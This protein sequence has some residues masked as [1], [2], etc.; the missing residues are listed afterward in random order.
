[1]RNSPQ[2][3]R[4]SLIHEVSRSQTHYGGWDSSGRVISSSQRPLPD[5][6]QHSKDRHAQ[7]PPADKG[8]LIHEVSRSQTHHSGWDSSGRVISSSQR[9]LPD[10]TQHSQDR[11]PCLQWDSNPTISA[12]R[13][14][15]TY[16]LDCA[17]TGT[18]K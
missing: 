7:Q 1:M 4:A 16:A 13:R 2:R 12:G 5:N 17:A 8:L 18:G 11:H 14:P 10:N 15:Q 3:T 6:T 9:P